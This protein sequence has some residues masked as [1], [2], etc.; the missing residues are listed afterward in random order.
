MIKESQKVIVQRGTPERSRSIDFKRGV[1][2]TSLFLSSCRPLVGNPSSSTIFSTQP[3]PIETPPPTP[4]PAVIEGEFA[5]AG[6]LEALRQVEL[7]DSLRAT[8]ARAGY[9]VVVDSSIDRGR[10]LMAQI[11]GENPRVCFPA[12]PPNAPEDSVAISAITLEG[13][14]DPWTCI[15]AR[16]T[17]ANREVNPGTYL[18]L[19][20]N[21]QTGEVPGKLPAVY[22]ASANVELNLQSGEVLVNGRR[23]WFMGSGMAEL[24]PTSTVTPAPTEIPTPTEAPMYT[25]PLVDISGYQSRGYIQIREH[26]Q[27]FEDLTIF[28]IW[29]VAPLTL[30]QSSTENGGGIT[31]QIWGFELSG[32]EYYKF[33]ILGAPCELRTVQGEPARYV[34]IGEDLDELTPAQYANPVLF[35]IE[36]AVS[37]AYLDRMG[38]IF[39]GCREILGGL[40]PQEADR[41]RSFF[42]R[43]DTQGFAIDEAGI[44]D[45]SKIIWVVDVLTH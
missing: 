21:T 41:L 38:R 5:G 26:Q 30:I 1:M 24:A 36:E 33:R 45:L 20:I 12:L 37:P 10:L 23:V 6:G 28:D 15:T 19:L 25:G 2:I 3:R 4:T 18:T 29:F 43:G 22:P 27:R 8:L 13:L 14:T 35:G 39:P 34:K 17:E 7:N 31:E 44:V 40:T 11:A 16:T 9:E 32:K 42:T